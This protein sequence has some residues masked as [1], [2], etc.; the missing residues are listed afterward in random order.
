MLRCYLNQSEISIAWIKIKV[1]LWQGGPPDKLWDGIGAEYLVHERSVMAIIN[2]HN[3]HDYDRYHRYTIS[4][5]T[6]NDHHGCEDDDDNNAKWRTPNATWIT[7]SKE[8]ELERNIAKKIGMNLSLYIWRH[9]RHSLLMKHKRNTLNYTNHF[10]EVIC[11]KFNDF[12]NARTWIHVLLFW[13]LSAYKND[14]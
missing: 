8:L 6:Q 1:T 13:M 4:S 7:S 14:Q 9:V 2:E 10:V 3:C 5:L 11:G 12:T